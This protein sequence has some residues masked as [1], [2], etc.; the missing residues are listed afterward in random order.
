MT[1]Q[2]NPNIH[3]SKGAKINDC[4]ISFPYCYQSCFYRSSGK[5]LYPTF[6]SAM[7]MQWLGSEVRQLKAWAFHEAGYGTTEKKARYM[8]AVD[9]YD[10]VLRLIK[11]LDNLGT[12]KR[13]GGQIIRNHEDIFCLQCGAKHYGNGDIIPTIDG[14]EVKPRKGGY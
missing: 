7:D 12:C 9:A 14:E 2:D 3:Q 13:C 1:S 6:K 5:C 10:A 11:R 8:S 4:P